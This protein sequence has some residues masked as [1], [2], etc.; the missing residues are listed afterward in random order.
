MHLLSLQVVFAP[1]RVVY[2]MVGARAMNHRAIIAAFIVLWVGGFVVVYRQEQKIEQNTQLIERSRH[3]ACLR[4]QVVDREFNQRAILFSLL[5]QSAQEGA[6]TKAGK[7]LA[8]TQEG[9][10]GWWVSYSPRNGNNNAEG[11]WCQWVHLGGASSDLCSLRLHVSS[12]K[13]P[14]R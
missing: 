9:W 13:R 4:G 6:R 12:R 3:T 2:S 5:I 8:I 14:N 1:L 10:E 7:R 11:Q